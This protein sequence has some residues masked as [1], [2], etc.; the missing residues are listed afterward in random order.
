[1]ALT[2]TPIVTEL[3]RLPKQNKWQFE[4]LKRSQFDIKL[5]YQ[6][7]TII[8]GDVF[9]QYAAE[10]RLIGESSQLFL[11]LFTDVRPL[12]LFLCMSTALVYEPSDLFRGIPR[13]VYRTFFLQV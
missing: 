4:G 8:N 6:P 1:M 10:K 2:L 3:L 9:D 12:R 13:I 11:R 5:G 7:G